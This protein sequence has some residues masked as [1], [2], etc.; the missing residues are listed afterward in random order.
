MII[1]LKFTNLYSHHE[2]ELDDKFWNI[3]YADYRKIR[4]F[5]VNKWA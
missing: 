1:D 3:Y 4:M 5:H 2:N